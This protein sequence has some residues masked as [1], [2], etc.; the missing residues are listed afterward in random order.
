MHVDAVDWEYVLLSNISVSA[1]ENE[2]L[3]FTVA[4]SFSYSAFSLPR[5]AVLCKVGQL[6]LGGSTVDVTNLEA[7]QKTTVDLSCF[8]L[9]FFVNE[10]AMRPLTNSNVVI[11]FYRYQR[12]PYYQ[13]FVRYL[14]QVGQPVPDYEQQYEHL[15]RYF[16]SHPC[17]HTYGKFTLEG[18]MAS[19]PNT[20]SLQDVPSTEGAAHKLAR[21]D[22]YKYRAANF[23]FGCNANI[24]AQVTSF[25]EFNALRKNQLLRFY[26]DLKENIG[27][28]AQALSKARQAAS[29]YRDYCK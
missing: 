16:H 1:A 20:K 9:E 28:C 25:C 13:F 23:M 6:S 29:K 10:S 2:D 3:T 5:F 14:K 11:D 27:G 21:S 26:Q 24:L 12:A 7:L 18:A 19:T 8:M 22:Y 4:K 15:M 17:L